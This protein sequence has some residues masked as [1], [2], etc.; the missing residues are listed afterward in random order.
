MVAE[1]WSEN[2]AK[3]KMIRMKSGI[4]FR[5]ERALA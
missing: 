1:F 2:H 5:K 3:I 4:M